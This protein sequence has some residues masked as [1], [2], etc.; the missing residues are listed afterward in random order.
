VG[1]TLSN[2]LDRVIRAGGPADP[3]FSRQR[4]LW[5]ALGMACLKNLVHPSLVFGMSLLLGLRGLPVAVM[6]VASSLPIGA[7]VFLFSQ[8][9]KVAE[10]EVTSAVAVSTL[11]ALMTVPLAMAGVVWVM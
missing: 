3:Q 11:A 5:S 7:N 9:Y 4:I 8:R 6:M 2:V 10:D 1:I